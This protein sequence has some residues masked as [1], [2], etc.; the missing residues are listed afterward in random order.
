MNERLKKLYK[1]VILEHNDQP[2]FFEK[3]ENATHV[4]KAYN[5]L[6]GD[7][8]ELF[9]EIKDNQ[10]ES[11]TFHGFGCAISKASTSVLVKK[12]KGKTIDEAQLIVLLVPPLQDSC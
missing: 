4:L 12:L 6:C 3:N 7:R 10:I 9:F 11:L 1:E 8:F 2:F 5:P